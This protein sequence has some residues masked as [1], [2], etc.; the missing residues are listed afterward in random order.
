MSGPPPRTLR[1]H[2]AASIAIANMVGTGVF[3]SLGYQVSGTPSAFALL[4]LWVLGGI[5]AFCGA[6]SYGELGAA[7]PRSGGEYHLLSVIYHP[8]AG[9]L[10]GWVS[11]TA[12]FA[13]PT[14]VAAIALGKYLAAVYPGF[15]VQ[16]AAAGAVLAFALIHSLSIGLGSWFQNGFTLIKIACMLLLILAGLSYGAPQPLD[17]LPSPESA[18]ML[19][20]PAFAVSLVYVSYAYTGWNASVYIAGE[21][22]NPQRD[23]PRALVLSTLL[24]TACYVGLNWAFLR[25]V[26]MAELAGQAEVGFLSARA[27]FGPAAGDA[28]S[29]AIAVLMLSTISAMVFVGARITQVMG[30]DY[31]MLRMLARRSP[32][33][34][35]VAAIVFQTA[36]TLLFIYTSSFE[37]VMIYASFSLMLT[38]SLTV[39]GVFVL[40]ARQPG[41]ERPYRTWGYPAAPLIFLAAN[42]WIIGYVLAER[43]LESAAGLGIMAAG[44]GVYALGR[45]RSR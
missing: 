19:L 3:T 16:H 15:P 42:L 30:E 26:P 6:L 25:T 22:R 39:A 33:H 23:L 34:T 20:S 36:V 31:P 35:P 32:R 21:L 29:V 18:A 45:R 11:A 40:R 28:L 9:F 14:A 24:V 41:L 4:M 44:L 5:I 27:M 17:L 7:L 13:A 37:Q 2:T 8:A 10:S 1:L 38:T 43:P 12:G